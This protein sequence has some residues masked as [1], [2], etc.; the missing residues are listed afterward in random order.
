MDVGIYSGDQKDIN[1]FHVVATWQALQYNPAILSDF[2]VLIWDEAHGIKAA[3]GQKLINEAGKHI[4][5]RFGVTGTFPKPEADKL[6]LLSSIGPILREIP[7]QWLI[8]H[9][10][11]AKIE[12][13]PIELNETYVDEDFPDYAS[14]KAF[15]SK[16]SA[17]MEIIADLI[18]SQC[19]THGNTLVLVNSIPFGEKL[20]ALIKGA[21]FLYGESPKDLR[22]EH[23]DMFEQQDD[24][25]VI[26]SS[27]IASTGI[28]I[29]RV[30]C[31]MLVDAGKSFIKCIQSIGRGLRKGHDKEAVAVVDVHSKQKWAK[32]HWKN[33]LGHYKEAGYPVL[34]V[35]KLRV[36]DN[37]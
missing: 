21:V 37:S 35:Q 15:L 9:G 24:L 2:Q 17:R 7:A 6:S 22:K 29:D 27:G 28:S 34:P 32:K 5:F 3:V 8:E 4:A 13:Q 25:I 16:S 11:L 14:E 12:I 23:Y 36:K 33:R 20:A 31:L 1:H 18:I 19:A 26:A 30:F 10:Y